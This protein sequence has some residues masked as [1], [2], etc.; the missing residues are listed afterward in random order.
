MKTIS[1][2]KYSGSGND[3]IIIDNRDG[4]F[5]KSEHAL[6]RALCARNTGIG[7][8]GLI[9]HEKSDTA[10]HRMRIFNRDGYETEMCGNGL[11]CFTRYLYNNDC[12]AGP[13]QIQSLERTHHCSVDGSQISVNMGDPTDIQWNLRIAFEETQMVV[14]TLNTGVSHAV[15]FIPLLDTFDITSWGPRIRNHKQ[16]QP[17][18]VNANFAEITDGEV[19]HLRTYE[20][21]VE[22]ETLACGTGATATA[23]AAAHLYGLTSPIAVQPQ[24]QD[25]LY[26]SFETT[27]EGYKNVIL[28]GPADQ[29]FEGGFKYPFPLIR[30]HSFAYN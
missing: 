3:F 18:G 15:A 17:K 26:I 5:P 23:L 9:L 1:F 10:D 25:L 24:S 29:T 28:T 27:E 4:Q 19:I 22:Q 13:F 14:H 11:R 20:R 8:D 6:V 30:S 2:Y 12:G 21:G 16:F 7:A